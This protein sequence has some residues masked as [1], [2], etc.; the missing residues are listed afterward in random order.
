MNITR[1]IYVSLTRTNRIFTI[2]KGKVKGNIYDEVY[3]ASPLAGI[4]LNEIYLK[5]Q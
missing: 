2:V 4:A 3:I 5:F 1:Y